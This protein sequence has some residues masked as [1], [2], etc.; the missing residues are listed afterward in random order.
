[1]TYCGQ[2]LR[3]KAV[4]SVVTNVSGIFL[5][6][7]TELG[8]SDFASALYVDITGC[9]TAGTRYNQHNKTENKMCVYNRWHKGIYV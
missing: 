5:T 7:G 8:I 1:M 4:I 2:R 6:F 9:R 3:S